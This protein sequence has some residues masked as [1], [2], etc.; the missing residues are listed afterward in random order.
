[1][2]N[3]FRR[4]SWFLI[5]YVFAALTSLTFLLIYS[6][7]DI[8]LFLNSHYN[9]FGDFFF[10][11]ITILGDGII[12]PFLALLLMFIRFRHAFFL[13]LTYAV[14][15]LFTQLL[16]RAFFWHVPRPTKFFDGIAQLHLVQG[17]EQ[18]S[19]KSFPS[20]HSTTAFAIMICFAVMV[21]NNF[22]KLLF[23]FLAT[24]IAYSRVYLSQHFLVDIL[25]GSFIG[26][27]TGLL[28]N[29]YVA[30]LKWGWLDKSL[31]TIKKS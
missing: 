30:S 22:L 14:S 2:Y 16:K 24:L 17:V 6:K 26:V 10:K 28:L 21:R 11:Y 18:L 29:Q 25:A 1:M 19:M 3:I 9:S 8:H 13:L 7:A 12:I 27:I 20:G 5:P 23:F 4:N 15:G 31:L